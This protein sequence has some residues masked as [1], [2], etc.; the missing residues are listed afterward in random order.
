M[1]R[2]RGQ[3]AAEFA[4]IAEI[5]ALADK[6]AFLAW[7]R[8]NRKMLGELSPPEF[9]RVIGHYSARLRRID[10]EAGEGGKP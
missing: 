8:A 7:K 5:N 10:V 9:Q 2:L 1:A 3:S 6:P 4:A